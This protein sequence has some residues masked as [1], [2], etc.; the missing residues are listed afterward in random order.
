MRTR[1]PG[2]VIFQRV[3]QQIRKNVPDARWVGEHRRGLNRD[4]HLQGQAFVVEGCFQRSYRIGHQSLGR[5]GLQIEFHAAG[6]ETAH[7]QKVLDDL[8]KPVGILAGRHQQF[9]LL[10]VQW[11]DAFFEQKMRSHANGSQ[12][13]F[14][15]V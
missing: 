4:I 11:A 12:G 10:G 2:G 8:L 5:L 1:P 6:F 9:G 7:V 13:S 14:Q 15:F 3:G